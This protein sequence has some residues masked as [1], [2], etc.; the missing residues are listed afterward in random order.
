MRLLQT[1]KFLQRGAQKYI[2]ALLKSA[3][4]VFLFFSI[5]IVLSWLRVAFFFSFLAAR[6]V[7]DSDAY[8]LQYEFGFVDSSGAFQPWVTQTS[9]EYSIAVPPGNG[10]DNQLTL[11]VNVKDAFGSAK[12]VE[13]NVT[14][15]PAA[16]VNEDKVGGL[17]DNGL[18]QAQDTGDYSQV[19]PNLRNILE[20]LKQSANVSGK[21]WNF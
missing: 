11:R 10:V 16:S 19:V 15:T 3:L 8:P 2:N 14:I 9:Q 4:A 13:K 5:S 6:W 20:V 7:T 1:L 12:S 21:V 17:I 18:Q